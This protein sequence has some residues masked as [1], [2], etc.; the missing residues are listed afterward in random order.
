M[1]KRLISFLL[2]FAMLLSMV[3]T[4]FAADSNSAMTQSLEAVELYDGLAYGEQ[5]VKNDPIWTA[6]WVSWKTE[7]PVCCSSRRWS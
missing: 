4:A 2:V 1:K 5:T 3:P 7:S 6:S